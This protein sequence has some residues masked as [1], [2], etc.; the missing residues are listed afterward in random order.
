MAKTKSDYTVKTNYKDNI[1]RPDKSVS[2]PRITIKG[3]SSIAAVTFPV[4]SDFGM[5]SQSQLLNYR[6]RNLKL[7][8]IK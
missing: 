8:R 2:Y 7:F 1:W 3:E 6:L 5:D 4:S